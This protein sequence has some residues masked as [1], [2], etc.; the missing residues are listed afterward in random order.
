M[1][2]VFEELKQLRAMLED[3]THRIT[4]L[5]GKFEQLP[6]GEVLARTH[7]VSHQKHTD[8]ITDTLHR[9]RYNADTCCH[10]P[11]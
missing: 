3:K 2:L 5:E 9:H 8:I 1:A 10:L 6:S 11:I 7:I 4:E